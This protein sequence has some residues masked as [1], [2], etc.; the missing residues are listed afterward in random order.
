M[1]NVTYIRKELAEVLAQYELILDCLAGPD[2]IKKGRQKYLLKPNPADTS[3]E[4][5]KRY[6]AYLERAVFVNFVRRT[7]AGLVGE[8]FSKEPEVS[9]NGV[10]QNL[11]DDVSGETVP[12][13]QQARK[14]LAFVLSLSR[15]GLLVDFPASEASK[16]EMNRGLKRPVI[17]LYGPRQIVNWRTYSEN[18][19]E[20]LSMVEIAEGWPFYDD[21]FEIKHCL[22]Y[23]VLKLTPEGV[24]I[25]T[26]MEKSPSEWDGYTIKKKNSVYELKQTTAMLDYNGVPVMQIPFFFIGSENNDSNVDL[27]NFYDLAYLNIAH[28]RNSADY[29]EN[30]FICGRSTPFISGLTEDWLNKVLKG[31]VNFGSTGGI[32]GPEGS[33]AKLLEMKPNSALLEAMQHKEN[34][35]IALGAK[36]VEQ[37]KVQRT[38]FETGVQTK[39]ETSI[40]ATCANN[41]SAAYTMALRFCST[42]YYG[43]QDETSFIKLNTLFNLSTLTPEGRREIIA[44]WKDGALSWDEMRMN[45]RTSELLLLEDKAVKAQI[46][47]DSEKKLEN[48]IKLNNTR[49]KLNGA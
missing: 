18:G 19:L 34:Q 35:M 11:V 33:D 5:K 38:A 21:G 3:E 42:F 1:I 22:T 30:L 43:T 12:L 14:A 27:P 25:E 31:Q 47:A 23:K 46:E 44:A 39:S 29:E 10:L 36:L 6:D 24:M 8:V 17:K 32:A 49:G 15:C 45:L 13:V 40:L 48:E 2:K 41:V 37:K 16:D 26:Y 9:V 7:L 28:Y 4:N 20:R